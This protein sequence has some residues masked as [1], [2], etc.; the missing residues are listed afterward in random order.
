MPLLATFSNDSTGL[1]LPSMSY[2]EMD[3]SLQDDNKSGEELTLVFKL[4]DPIT[5]MSVGIIPSATWK[6]LSNGIKQEVIV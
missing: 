3:P 2:N 4:G 6:L 5:K 1:E